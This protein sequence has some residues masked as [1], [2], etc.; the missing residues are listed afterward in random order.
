MRNFEEL[1]KKELICVLFVNN[2]RTEEL[3]LTLYS[4]RTK[5]YYLVVRKSS[6]DFSRTYK[7]LLHIERDA[8]QELKDAIKQHAT[9]MILDFY[10]IDKNLAN[11]AKIPRTSNEQLEENLDKLSKAKILDKV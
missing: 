7:T 4:V 1:Y 3:R 9:D 2:E 5:D 8:I 6:T 10:Y 11:K